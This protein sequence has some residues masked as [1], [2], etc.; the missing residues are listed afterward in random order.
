M[1]TMKRSL[2]HQMKR[3]VEDQSKSGR[4]ATSSE[5]LRDL[6]RRDRDRGR[7]EAV[8]EIQAFV[9]VGLASGASSPFDSKAFKARMRA[10][11]A[12]D[13]RLN[14]PVCG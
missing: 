6:I 2:P 8:A 11:N 13:E 4:Y 12:R 14:H 7:A 9:D 1:G 5:N 3:W 10:G